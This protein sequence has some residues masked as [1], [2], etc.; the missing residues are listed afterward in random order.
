MFQKAAVRIINPF[1][2]QFQFVMAIIN[3]G[4]SVKEDSFALQF[5]NCN[6]DMQTRPMKPKS[7]Q[8]DFSEFLLEKS[9]WYV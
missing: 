4:F 8:I 7:C 2:K 6:C 3:I 9:G 1:L 5:A